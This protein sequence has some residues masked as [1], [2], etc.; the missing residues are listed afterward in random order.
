MDRHGVDGKPS[1]WILTLATKQLV[2]LIEQ[3]SSPVWN[4]R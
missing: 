2:R 1:I 3:G 4:G